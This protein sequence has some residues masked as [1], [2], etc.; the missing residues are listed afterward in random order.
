MIWDWRIKKSE[1]DLRSKRD[2]GLDFF[3][4]VSSDPHSGSVISPDSDPEAVVDPDSDFEVVA[5]FDSGIVVVD[6]DSG[7]FLILDSKPDLQSLRWRFPEDNY[8]QIREDQDH[9]HHRI[10]YRSHIHNRSLHCQATTMDWSSPDFES[11]ALVR[12]EKG[13]Q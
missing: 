9:H 11:D 5:D 13:L 8:L 4:S 7:L 3:G 12:A 1:Q 6:P 2:F 10:R